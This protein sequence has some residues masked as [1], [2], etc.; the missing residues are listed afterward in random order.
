MIKESRLGCLQSPIFLLS[1]L[2][3]RYIV[4]R[5]PSLRSYGK[6]DIGGPKNSRL[7]KP[8]E[9]YQVNNVKLIF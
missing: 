4:L 2:S 3:A 9:M 1:K 7:Y 8:P 5:A 6:I